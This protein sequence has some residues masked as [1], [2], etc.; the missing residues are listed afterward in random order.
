MALSQ[1]NRIFYLLSLCE[2]SPFACHAFVFP[3]CTLQSE[4]VL[5]RGSFDSFFSCAGKC[6]IA[7]VLSFWSRLK[8]L[9]VSTIRMVPTEGIWD[10]SYKAKGEWRRFC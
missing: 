3:P 2:L 1:V 10:R 6:R 5:H 9:A 4:G 8:R 7:V